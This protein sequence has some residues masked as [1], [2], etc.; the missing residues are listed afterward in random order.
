[1]ARTRK[2][3]SPNWGAV[4]ATANQMHEKD[5]KAVDRTQSE[6]QQRSYVP[7]EQIKQREQN[8]REIN[9]KHVAALI[10]SIATLGLLE[11]L[12]VDNRYRLLAGGHRLAA[13]LS[14]K[15]TDSAVFE[16]VFPNSLIPV[17]VMPFDAAK[18]AE[19]ALQCEV[20]ENEHRRDYTS[21]EVR[22]LADRLL[23][24]GYVS[25]RARPKAGSKALVPALRIIVGKSR[26]TIMR[27]LSES[28][29]AAEDAQVYVSNETYIAETKA[30]DKAWKQLKTFQKIHIDTEE[31]TPKRAALLKKLPKML[32]LI[33]EVMVEI[34]RL[35]DYD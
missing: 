9:P 20:A 8:T 32:D 14:I 24:A 31:V 4:Q 23:A 11:P 3:S 13:I 17:R 1:M 35:A 15:E 10:D 29:Q 7:L 33:E 27:Y 19:K 26:A 16:K 21:K 18:E 28:T 12:V 30:L 5:K 22:A 34:D 6:R 2:K 25:S